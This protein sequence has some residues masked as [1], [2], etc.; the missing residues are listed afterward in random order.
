MKTKQSASRSL[1]YLLS[2][3]SPVAEANFAPAAP[4]APSTPA[5]PR[6]SPY[7]SLFK[8]IN[9]LSVNPQDFATLKELGIQIEHLAPDIM[10]S[11]E[12]RR[13]ARE[14]RLRLHLAVLRTI[15]QMTDPA[16]DP[17]DV[18]SLNVAAPPG[19]SISAGASPSA[20]KDPK[21]RRQYEEAIAR[22]EEKGRNYILQVELRRF[23]E[24]WF[25][26]TVKFVSDHYA[27]T[28]QD[29]QEIAS[30]VEGRVADGDRRKI[31]KRAVEDPGK[32]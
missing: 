27:R 28:A 3:L 14:A 29:A 20:I 24:A 8:Q 13:K 30:A 32:R 7:D 17:K 26:K 10:G 23:D 5:E 4:T 21:M 11:P 2:L 6:E 18:P 22:N 1:V 31:L 9:A 25:A 16:F 12:D 19:A 15:A